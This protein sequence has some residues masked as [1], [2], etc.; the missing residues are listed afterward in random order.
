MKVS[1]GQPYNN[2]KYAAS[3]NSVLVKCSGKKKIENAKILGDLGLSL[4]IGVAAGCISAGILSRKKLPNVFVN[5]LGVGTM[6]S[7]ITYI[8]TLL[9]IPFRLK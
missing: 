1:F 9:A 3:R 7:Y 5:S 8:G 4:G 2:F 6:V